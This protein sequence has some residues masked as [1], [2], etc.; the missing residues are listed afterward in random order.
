MN[1]FFTRT[2]H[3]DYVVRLK[4]AIRA[5]GDVVYDIGIGDIIPKEDDIVVVW[6]V[7]NARRWQDLGCDNV[8][9]FER[10]YLGDRMH[11]LSLG[12]DDLNGKANFYNSYVPQDRWDNYWKTGMSEWKNDGE[13][14]LI[15]GQVTTDQS[16]SDC[17]DYN[18]WLNDTI[19]ALKSKG[20]EVVFRPHPL[21]E[22]GY[23]VKDVVISSHKNFMEDLKRAKCL[24]TWSSTTSVTAAYSGVP[25]VVFSDFAMTKEVSSHSLNDL[26]FKPDRTNW[27]RKLAYC[28][29]N[30][31]ELTN[32]DAWYHVKTRFYY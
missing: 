2:P 24:V 29:W 23:D 15:A 30:L 22:V 28:Q 8:L 21:E 20:H 11:W 10:G 18:R 1:V 12:W 32:G 19:Q 26:A 5:C 25:S 13:V 6:G 3:Q 17:L 4:Q 9:I 27:G 7:V 16:L 31:E 14:V